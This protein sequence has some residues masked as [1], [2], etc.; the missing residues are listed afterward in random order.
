MY[1]ND[2]DIDYI[3]HPTAPYQL[4][5][6]R[7]RIQHWDTLAAKSKQPPPRIK[8]PTR[9]KRL[10]GQPP[11]KKAIPIQPTPSK[12]RSPTRS[13]STSSSSVVV[14]LSDTPSSCS[15]GSDSDRRLALLYVTNSIH[16]SLSDQYYPLIQ[17]V[18]LPVPHT[19]LATS[20]QHSIPTPSEHSDVEEATRISAPPKQP[21][22]LSKSIAAI[23][24]LTNRLISHLADNITPPNISPQT[25]IRTLLAPP[26]YTEEET[27]Q[28]TPQESRQIQPVHQSSPPT[29]CP[30]HA[31]PTWNYPTPYILPTPIIPPQLY[32]SDD[33]HTTH[34]LNP[35][36]R[37]QPPHH[38]PWHIPVSPSSLSPYVLPQTHAIP[39]I[40]P[41]RALPPPP[42][43]TPPIQLINAQTQTPPPPL[44]YNQ[45]TQTTFMYACDQ[46]SAYND[47]YH[48]TPFVS[49]LRALCIRELTLLLRDSLHMIEARMGNWAR[50]MTEHAIQ[51][52]PHVLVPSLVSFIDRCNT[53][54]PDNQTTDPYIPP[55]LISAF[56]LHSHMIV[57]TCQVLIHNSLFVPLTYYTT[58]SRWPH[59]FTPLLRNITRAVRHFYNACITHIRVCNT[60]ETC[61]SSTVYQASIKAFIRLFCTET[62][63]TRNFF[64][65]CRQRLSPHTFRETLPT[66]PDI[67]VPV[68]QDI[69]SLLSRTIYSPGVTHTSQRY[70]AS[71]LHSLLFEPENAPDFPH[72]DQ[73][74]SS[75]VLHNYTILNLPSKHF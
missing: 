28:S 61:T 17:I 7:Q 14:E 36:W 6:V 65:R 66:H 18:A 40:P 67:P 51:V 16:Y 71:Q 41:R 50:F 21:S 10:A 26:G 56:L 31:P 48:T 45:V 27:P 72:I 15:S 54:S 30:H 53:T 58:V 29:L 38:Y 37:Q 32:P 44:T 47:C 33:H 73:F 5:R 57:Y 11:K 52:I 25:I 39:N 75:N 22:F 35:H 74:F 23:P 8:Q 59:T 63:K 55:D 2:N 60:N 1:D 3:S 24:R 49:Q 34:F 12:V 46:C 9:T 64:I 43:P 70:T 13:S 69:P 4:R 68:D 19:Q 42:P 62:L 20:S